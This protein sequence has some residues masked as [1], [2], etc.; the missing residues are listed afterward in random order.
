MGW[1]L[2]RFLRYIELNPVR[3]RMVKRAERWRWSSAWAHF[4]GSDD[5][6]RL[7]LEQWAHSFGAANLAGAAEAWREFVEGPGEEAAENAGR[8]VR[9]AASGSGFNR[10]RG[11]VPP[12]MV[13]GAGSPP[14]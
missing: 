6:G 3:A 2:S 1:G 11:W 14:V 8:A 13:A 10:V 7:C 4:A 9:T 12:V 5:G